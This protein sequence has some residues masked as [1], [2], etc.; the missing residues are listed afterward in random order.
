MKVF[1]SLLILMSLL[2]PEAVAH[3]YK[4]AVPTNIDVIPGDKKITLRWTHPEPPDLDSS[5]YG[6]QWGTKKFS[7]FHG[8][9]LLGLLFHK[10]RI[11][12]QPG[13]LT[14]NHILIGYVI[15]AIKTTMTTLANIP[16]P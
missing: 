9:L 15:V 7:T 2:I 13:L 14:D 11:T 5:K 16:Y 8:L 10:I 6:F 4:S 1:V 12:Y 3:N